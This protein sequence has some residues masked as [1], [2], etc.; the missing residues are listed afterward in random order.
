M[1]KKHLALFL[2]IFTLSGFSG[3][4]YESIWT[5]Y[6]KLFLGHAAYAQTL[7]LAIFMGGMAFGS[8]MCSKYSIKW[9]NLLIG[10][11]LVEGAI[12]LFAMIFHNAFDQ[13][14]Q[15]SYTSII[16]L[17]NSASLA[18]IYTWTL[19]AL[20][21]LPQ[22]ILLG[23]TFPL[24][25]AGIL[26]LSPNNPGR[27][28]A[29]FYFTN[30]L[31]AAIGVLV[32]GFILIRFLGLPWTIRTAGL[33]NIAVALS[34][35]RLMK[36]QIIQPVSVKV[37]KKIRQERPADNGYLLF[38][39]ISFLTGTASFIYEIGWIRMLS[40][41]LGSSTHA[42]ELMLSAFIFGLAFGGLWIQRR[43]DGIAAPERTLAYVQ[44]VMGLLALSTLLLYGNTFEVMKWLVQTLSRTNT[45]YALFN[46]SSNAIALAVMLPTTFCAGMTLPLITYQLI[47]QG[48]GERSIGQVYAANT[49]GAILG[50]FF[51]I[52]V[53]M[54]MLGLKGLIVFG[55]GLDIALG[56]LLLWSAKNAT[57]KRLPAIVTAL[58]IFAIAATLL[59]VKL[60]AY[61]MA[62]GVYRIG[63]LL[64]EENSRLLYHRDGKTA[65]V[66]VARFNNGAISIRTNGKSDAAIN[67]DT[68][69]AAHRDEDTMILLAVIPMALNPQAETIANIG[70]GSGLTTH[71]LLSN[72]RIKQ[73]DTV[74]IEGK[75][76]E[77]A[78]NFR[79]RVELAF[80][81]PRSKISIDDA[82]KFFA[83]HNIKYDMI[84]SE[85]SNPW[86]S[87]VSGLFSEEFYRLVSRHLTEN[88]SF[89]QWLQL[90]EMDN[91]LVVSV[92]K[93][94][95]SHFNDFVIYAA[96]REN[97][98]LIA[99]NNGKIAA[100]DPALLR[101]PD[102]AAAL[103]RIH[104]N[105]MQDIEI[106]K[107]GNKKI[108]R[109]LME[110]FSIRAN[111]D[112]NP[113]LDQNAVRARFFQTNASD[114][115]RIAH[116]PLP[117]LEM[118]TGSA[119]DRGA[120]D[121]TPSGSF[122]ETKSAYEAMMA[123]DFILEGRFDSRYGNVSMDTKRLALQLRQIFYDC[124]SLSGEDAGM[125]SLF[126]TFIIM[127]S[128]LRPHE[129]DVVWKRL[130][131][132]PCARSLS[133]E[134]RNWIALFKAVG[135]RDATGM[136]RAAQTMLESGQRLPPDALKY[137]VLSGMMG[138]LRQGDREGSLKLWSRYQPEIFGADNPDLLFRLLAAESAPN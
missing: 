73:V 112:Y 82:K 21:I 16:P 2:L 134:K 13:A 19:S 126:D 107:V 17:F 63:D 109:K 91:E 74:E 128:Y 55:A 58:C 7:V 66:S 132:A 106:R 133:T 20:M 32:S 79:P 23:M 8:W 61:K 36:S 62:S 92:L 22:S 71:T 105:G 3:L 115:V 95:S 39:F 53:G 44:V 113:V 54:P 31:G 60:D 130:D 117:S 97:I 68:R 89:V 33:I 29:L 69:G 110:S 78:Q 77:A 70:F 124:R 11:A 101:Y 76:V 86:V 6:L 5:H 24:M 49:V 93:A 138:H 67:M 47:R 38:L 135:K 122:F 41:V 136:A 96:D 30:S 98:I 26:R 50:V 119:P 28:I 99:R 127:S 88:G 42:F 114:F 84:L 121:I 9:K 125:K 10:Y 48:H 102:I 87:G 103:A 65:T 80:S 18:S 81:D 59:F 51:A 34:V 40:L 118:L 137:V 85:P 45:G 131:S 56:V 25:S 108:L 83:V 15:I 75:M 27:T 120:T 35:W 94:V 104:I 64:T 57:T 4:I 111:S 12:G 100:P 37:D 46:L 14:V 43:I 52:H 129:L 123:R 72:P 116:M 90:Y 1:N